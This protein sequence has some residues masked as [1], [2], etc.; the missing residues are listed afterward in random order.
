MCV[1]VMDPQFAVVKRGC[2]KLHP[3]QCFPSSYIQSQH[4]F[5]YN[6]IK[7]TY[8]CNLRHWTLWSMSGS[9]YVHVEYSAEHTYLSSLAYI[10]TPRSSHWY[11][12]VKRTSKHSTLIEVQIRGEGTWCVYFDFRNW[13]R[14]CA[15][16]NMGQSW[17]CTECGHPGHSSS[18]F[19]CSRVACRY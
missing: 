14:M 18:M 19:W 13:T 2:L 7:H 11:V 15:T 4:R 10:N 12:L 16:Q 9:M 1:W 3:C 17:M 8:S 5:W 6:R